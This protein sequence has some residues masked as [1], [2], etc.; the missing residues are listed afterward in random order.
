MLRDV[1]GSH[2][3]PTAEG[4]G[5]DGRVAR[6][7]KRR[8]VRGIDPR[9]RVE[10]VRLAR[11]VGDVVEERTELRAGQLRSRVGHELHDSGEVE[12]GRDRRADVVEDVDDAALRPQLLLV[13]LPLDAQ[14][15]QVGHGRERLDRALVERAP[16]EDP[17]HTEHPLPE[18]QRIAGERHQLLA[19]GPVPVAGPRIVPHVVREV[20]YTLGHDGPDLELPDGHAAVLLTRSADGAGAGTEVDRVAARASGST[21]R[22]TPRRAARPPP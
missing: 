8:E 15:D 22:R 13:P 18:E 16:G 14:G 1:V 20:R 17:E 3:W 2:R 11:L 4:R 21:H 10:H 6:Q 9:Q 7:R 19:P 5:E 12:L